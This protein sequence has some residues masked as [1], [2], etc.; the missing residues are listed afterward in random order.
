MIAGNTRKTHPILRTRI[1]IIIPL[2]LLILTHHQYVRGEISLTLSEDFATDPISGGRF[3]QQ[4]AGTE[5]AFT[6]D[7]ARGAIQA[8]LDLDADAASFLSGELPL[9][10]DRQT[11]SFSVRF[12]ITEVDEAGGGLI[13]TAVIGLVTTR[14]VDNFGDGLTL[15]LAARDGRIFAGPNIDSA[16]FPKRSATNIVLEVGQEYLAFLQYRGDSRTLRLDIFGGPS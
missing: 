7:A 11:F 14:H 9:V 10:T 3:T 4:T 16:G 13:P 1:S 5:S 12:R 2:L 6:H 15:A 8:V